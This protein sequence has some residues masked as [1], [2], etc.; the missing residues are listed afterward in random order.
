MSLHPLWN[1]FKDQWACIPYGATLGRP[2]GLHPL[3]HNLVEDRWAC[4]LDRHMCV[5][6]SMH[7][8]YWVHYSVFTGF[9]STIGLASHGTVLERP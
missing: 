6:N 2:M 1:N 9:H 7:V 8:F 5:F 4:I 3:W